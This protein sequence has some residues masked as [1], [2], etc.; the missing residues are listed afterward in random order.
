MLLDID[1]GLE[2]ELREVVVEGTGSQLGA[3]AQGNGDEIPPDW[4]RGVTRLGATE[5]NDA[6]HVEEL[7]VTKAL[8]VDEIPDVSLIEREGLEAI[9]GEWP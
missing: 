6:N 2:L 1:Q 4:D 7:P 3:V 9:L 5:E 8:A